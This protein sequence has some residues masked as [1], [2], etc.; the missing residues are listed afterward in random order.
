MTA[1]TVGQWQENIQNTS[2]N[3]DIAASP[4][5][6]NVVLLTSAAITANSNSA[7][8]TNSRW[9][10]LKVFIKTGSFGAGATAITIKIQ[11]K[12]PVSN[13]Y[14]DILTSAS[15]SASAFVVLSVH[16]TI[17]ASANVAAKD[18]LP[19]TWRVTY[20]ATDWGTSGSTLGI[21]CAMNV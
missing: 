21:S 10:G 8:Q 14:Y 6:D 20:Q 5:S 3:S 9:C 15:L 13:T 12:D 16:P 18:F 1:G 19:K 4:N 2:A 11:G 7:D 17:D